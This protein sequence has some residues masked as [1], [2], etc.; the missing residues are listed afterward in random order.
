MVALQAVVEKRYIDVH[1]SVKSLGA[2]SSLPTEH[3]WERLF[4]ALSKTPMH[5][6]SSPSVFWP[7]SIPS[8]Q[9]ISRY[10][11]LCSGDP[12]AITPIA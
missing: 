8:P 11:V 12:T 3:Q 5:T 4:H 1:M 2:H 9:A 10:L 6:S 7:L